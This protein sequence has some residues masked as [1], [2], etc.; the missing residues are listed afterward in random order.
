MPATARIE[1]ASDL[2]TYLEGKDSLAYRYIQLL[3]KAAV[4]GYPVGM[5]EETQKEEALTDWEVAACLPEN[6]REDI[7]VDSITETREKLNRASEIVTRHG[8]RMGKP[9]FKL[10]S[11]LTD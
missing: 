8:H 1:T 11:E 9:T 2:L 3:R 7:T 4:K 5:R 6:R 10:N